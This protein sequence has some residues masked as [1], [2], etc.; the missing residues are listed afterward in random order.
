MSLRTAALADR[1]DSSERPLV[2]LDDIA[3]G[4]DGRPVLERLALALYPGQFAGIV[5]PS[6]SGKTTVLRAILGLADLYHGAVRFPSTG[7][8]KRPRIGYVPQLETID[9]SFPVTVEQVVLM[10][11]AA[12]SGPLPWAS[13]GDRRR[14]Q[15][16]L[17]RLGIAAA[18]VPGQSADPLATAPLA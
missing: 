8:G 3:C 13:R 14:M 12:E 15:E 4:Y 10:G 17:E 18:C 1:L 16:L 2:E 11:L 7:D 6:G 9:W 5:G